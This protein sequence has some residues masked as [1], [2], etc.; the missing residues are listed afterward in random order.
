MGIAELVI[1]LAGQRIDIQ[2]E[3]IIVNAVVNACRPLA[4]GICEMARQ[5][6]NFNSICLLSDNKANKT[7]IHTKI[8]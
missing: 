6:K 5:Q 4:T 2:P 8:C 3:C 1:M 7:L